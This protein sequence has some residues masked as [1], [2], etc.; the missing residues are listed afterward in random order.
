MR[1]LVC[2][3][4]LFVCVCVRADF[5]CA[6]FLCGLLCTD[7]FCSADFLCAD[8]SADIDVDFDEEYFGQGDRRENDNKILQKSLPKILFKI[9]GHLPVSPHL[10]TKK[11]WRHTWMPFLFLATLDSD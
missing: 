7:F 4:F 6:G 1:V 5:F 8:F 9:L 11:S 3:F 10:D 2:V